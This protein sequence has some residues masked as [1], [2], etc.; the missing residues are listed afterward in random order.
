MENIDEKIL[1]LSDLLRS[2]EEVKKIKELEIKIKD[3]KE[4]LKLQNEFNIAQ[5]EFNSALNHYSFNSKEIKP[6]QIQLANAKMKL[7]NNPLIS[8]YYLLL[9]KVNE[10]LHYIELNLLSLFKD[11]KTK[12]E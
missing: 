10:P 3:D 2:R 9:N 4:I 12:C 8:E 7:D 11:K 1:E 6:F 5:S